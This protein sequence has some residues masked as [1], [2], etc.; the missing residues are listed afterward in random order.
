MIFSKQ[1][2]NIEGTVALV[3]KFNHEHGVECEVWQAG[4]CLGRAVIDFENDR[5]TQNLTLPNAVFEDRTRLPYRVGDLVVYDY[6]PGVIF[7]VS[8]VTVDKGHLFLLAQGYSDGS[9]YETLSGQPLKVLNVPPENCRYY[10]GH[11]CLADFL[12]EGAA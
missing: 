12:V 11:L 8:R 4:A 10:E 6:K 3:P 1:V 7:S 9:P 5:V 2:D